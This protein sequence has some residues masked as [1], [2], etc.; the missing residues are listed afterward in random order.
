MDGEP[1]G[2]LQEAVLTPTNQTLVGIAVVFGEMQAPISSASVGEG[3]VASVDV[4]DFFGNLQGFQPG[5]WVSLHTT[6]LL[7]I[8]WVSHFS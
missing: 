7:A 5:I 6:A 1:L 3:V 4:S 2:L 8:V